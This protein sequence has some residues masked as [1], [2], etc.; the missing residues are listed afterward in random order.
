MIQIPRKQNLTF[1]DMLPIQ[2]VKG[3]VCIH[4]RFRATRR[5]LAIFTNVRVQAD[6]FHVEDLLS[7]LDSVICVSGFSSSPIEGIS[8][9][10]WRVFNIGVRTKFIFK[11]RIFEQQIPKLIPPDRNNIITGV[12]DFL[13]HRFSFFISI[14]RIFHGLCRWVCVDW[15]CKYTH[16]KSTRSNRKFHYSLHSNH[17]T[18]H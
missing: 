15:A 4:A 8:N 1:D 17:P 6:N 9:I 3:T 12:L 13:L 14:L 18:S 2:T 7:G 10:Y 16:S 5:K 11:A